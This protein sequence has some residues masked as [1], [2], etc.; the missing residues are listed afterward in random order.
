MSEPAVSMEPG[1]PMRRTQPLFENMIFGSQRTPGGVYDWNDVN[2]QT[3][4][5]DTTID[6]SFTLL[7]KGES[8]IFIRNVIGNIRILVPYELEVSIHHSVIAGSTTVFDIEEQR[9]FNQVLQVKT[10]GYDE[11]DPKL[12]I[13]TS[14]LVGNLEGTRI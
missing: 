8:V 12:K 14:L 11:A 6:L 9:V 10:G 5:G 3:G 1:K 4:V 2:I 13:F 7:P